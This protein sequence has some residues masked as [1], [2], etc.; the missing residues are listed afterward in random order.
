MTCSVVQAAGIEPT[1]GELHMH[2]D[3]TGRHCG[4]RPASQ[5]LTLTPLHLFGANPASMPAAS[6]RCT[7]QRLNHTAH[8]NTSTTAGG[9]RQKTPRVWLTHRP[10]ASQ[11][12]QVHSSLGVARPHTHAPGPSSQGEDVPWP[13]QPLWQGCG[14]RQRPDGVA[15][16]AGRH[17]CA[18]G[19]PACHR[20]CVTA[21]GIVGQGPESACAGCILAVRQRG[22]ALPTPLCRSCW[23]LCCQY[24]SCH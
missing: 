18:G 3:C 15:P 1:I 9:P 4:R 12:A 10:A 19:F 22:D 2:T 17:A 11:Q 21:G 13:V 23:V 24:L 20:F 6:K 5:W 16:V 14:I 8:C 7:P